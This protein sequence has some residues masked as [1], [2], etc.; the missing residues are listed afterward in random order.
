MLRLQ[1]LTLPGNPITPANWIGC[2]RCGDTLGAGLWQCQGCRGREDR[3]LLS[4]R[5]CSFFEVRRRLKPFFKKENKTKKE[6]ERRPREL[7]AADATTTGE[8]EGGTRQ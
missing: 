1:M 2:V 5:H 6:R 7:T 4:E 3:K 8:E